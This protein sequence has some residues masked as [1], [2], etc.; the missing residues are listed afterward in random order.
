ML[1]GK[2]HL[3]LCV[4]EGIAAVPGVLDEPALCCAALR[5]LQRNLC[6]V[7]G[8]DCNDALLIHAVDQI[9][10]AVPGGLQ[11]PAALDTAEIVPLIG[12]LSAVRLQDVCAVHVRDHIGSFICKD[13][14]GGDCLFGRAFRR[15]GRLRRGCLC[16][17]G[18][19]LCGCRGGFIS[20]T[21][22]S[23]H[24]G[25][26]DNSHHNQILRFLHIFSLP[27]FSDAGLTFFARAVMLS[28][29]CNVTLQSSP[30]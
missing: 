11:V 15:S 13:I 8:S 5:L 1:D 3:V 26:G 6:A 18:G 28:I 2:V 27:D 29:R 30:L 22:A 25:S 17:C 21:S 20:G 19:C 24:H 9:V 16:S 10:A 4:A 12:D 7:F 14:D 23:G